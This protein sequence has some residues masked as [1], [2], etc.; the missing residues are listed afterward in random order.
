M[1]NIGLLID[2]FGHILSFNHILLMML[3]VTLGILVGVCSGVGGSQRCV[4]AFAPHLLDGSDLGDHPA[5]L[6]V[7]GR[8]VRRIDD[9]H[10]VQHS[11]RALFRRDDLRRLPDGK[12]RVRQAGR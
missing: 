11:R 7:L 6:H 5:L 4:A 3:G 10:P 8:A 12:D 9:V 2:G 1:E